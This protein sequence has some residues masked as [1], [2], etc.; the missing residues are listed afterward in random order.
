MQTILLVCWGQS[1]EHEV[2]LRSA[3]FVYDNLL[4]AWYKVMLVGISKSNRRYRLDRA[5]LENTQIKDGG[6]K[7]IALCPWKKTIRIDDI[8]TTIDVLFP[9]NHGKTGEDGVIQW[10]AQILGVPCVWPWILSSVQCYH[11]HLAKQLLET[12]GVAVAP[13]IVVQK[14]QK[15]QPYEEVKQRLWNVLFI[16]PSAAG[17]SVWV[18]KVTSSIEYQQAL[19]IAFEVDDIVLIESWIEW[20]EIEFAVVW[21][22]ENMLVSVPG[23]IKSTRR[24]SY[25]EKYEE[26]STTECLIV[27]DLDKETMDRCIWIVKQSYQVLWC[28]WLSR[29]D[30]FLTPEWSFI[31]N[32]INTLPWFT[33][34]SMYPKLMEATWITA[35]ELMKKLIESVK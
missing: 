25:E 19:E 27:V 20:R 29:V 22:W 18:S 5:D 28:S 13:G 11:K 24:Y 8:V 23:E 34:I 4:L 33:S 15:I 9:V 17:S 35:P 10:I 12:S 32:E 16:K 26:S 2:S 7:E 30:W 14:D 1:H 21:S 31:I 6:V 3:Q